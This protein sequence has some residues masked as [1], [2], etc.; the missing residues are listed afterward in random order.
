M[1][2][3]LTVLLALAATPVFRQSET[4]APEPASIAAEQEVLAEA[5]DLAKQANAAFNA[6]RISEAREHLRGALELARTLRDRENGDFRMLLVVVGQQALNLDV[7]LADE[8]Y[9]LLLEVVADLPEDHSS[10]WQAR[11]GRA[12][13][14]SRTGRVREAIPLYDSVLASLERTQEPS[15]YV[16]QTYFNAGV[17][18]YEA[19]DTARATE[20]LQAAIDTY[21]AAGLP[22]DHPELLHARATIA[23]LRR[24][25]GDLLGAHAE[26]EAIVGIYAETLPPADPKYLNAASNLAGM[27]SLIGDLEGAIAVQGQVLAIC[28]ESLPEDDTTLQEARQSA[29]MYLTKAGRPGEASGILERSLAVMR[30]KYSHRNS[31]VV[32]AETLL[33]MAYFEIG[34]YAESLELLE[35][36]LEVTEKRKGGD[37]PDVRELRQSILAVRAKTGDRSVLANL[38]AMLEAYEA[39]LPPD[40]PDVLQAKATLSLSLMGAGRERDALT[41]AEEVLELRERTLSPTDPDL[42]TALE[43]VASLNLSLGDARSALALFDRAIAARRQ[44]QE[45]AHP[46]LLAARGS[47]SQALRALGRSEEAVV[48]LED[49]LRLQADALPPDHPERLGTT[50]ALGL[51]RADTGDLQGGY[52]LLVDALAGYEETLGDE[53][54]HV[55]VVMTNVALLSLRMG[56]LTGALSLFRKVHET[57]ARF[58]PEDSLAV[59]T[60]RANVASALANMGDDAAAHE[61]LSTLVPAFERAHPGHPQLEEARTMLLAGAVSLGLPDAVA[62]IEAALEHA[63]ERGLSRRGVTMAKMSLVTARHMAGDAAGARELLVEIRNSLVPDLPE[64]DPTRMT[65][66]TLLL[67]AELSLRDRESVS[68][69]VPER[70]AALHELLADAFVAAPGEARALAARQEDRVADLLQANELTG[71]GLADIAGLLEL[72]RALATSESRGTGD[73]ELAERR[74]ELRSLRERVNNLALGGFG[75]LDDAARREEL[76]SAARDRNRLLRELSGGRDLSAGMDVATIAAALPPGSAAVGYHRYERK[77]KP[78]R[79]DALLAIVVTHTGQVRRIELGPMGPIAEQV[80]AWLRVVQPAAGRG[81]SG[82][83]TGGGDATDIALGLRRALLDPVF[84]FLEIAPGTEVFVCPDDAMHLVPLDALPFGDEGE[85]VG[86]HVAIRREISF[87]RLV[88]PPAPSSGFGELL[89]LGDVDFGAPSDSSRPVPASMPFSSSAVWPSLPGTADEVSAIA[90]LWESSGGTPLVLSGKD[91]TRE[92]LVSELP[93]RRFVHLATHGWFAPES[94][95]G[96]ADVETSP[97][98]SLNRSLTPAISGLAPM[99]LCGLALSDANAGRDALGRLS[100]LLTAE[101]LSS[102]D[103]SACELAVLSACETNVGIHRAGQGILSL[104]TAL[105]AAGARSSI[106]SLWRV[107]DELTRRLMTELYAN[108]WTREMG[109]A[110]ALWSAK[111]SL[112]EAGHPVSA[113]AG[114]ILTGN[115]D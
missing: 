92:R 96:T 5:R 43:T 88:A 33:A 80:D 99:T 31:K 36:A 95:L 25:G 52:A 6:N 56:D 24:S 114:W 106:T 47:R 32:R 16:G 75:E 101:E 34:R 60:A 62:E 97:W 17:T 51:V 57:R 94:V 102:Y 103:L 49:V 91:A 65:I 39:T 15:L 4:P 90:E 110:D 89:A 64:T 112:R 68:A 67:R 23:L 48:E 14:L 54:D 72:R 30:E 11:K 107:D 10:H 28:E 86:D 78:A 42:L 8:T 21:E 1:S 74:A 66:E 71:E 84:A 85:V 2:A 53:N 87:A 3:L 104:Q 100:G 113:W 82:P 109:K 77:G 9:A 111:S 63:D 7:G 45:E 83:D 20:L 61:E 29:A 93:G 108:L 79:G 76:E 55:L 70:I 44:T 19:G 59:L 26:L 35:H 58:L 22:A 41:L 73:A 98:S 18:N 27:K 46:H 50:A 37:H 105:H 81:L 40:H 69:H 38:E 115:P 12:E 13:V